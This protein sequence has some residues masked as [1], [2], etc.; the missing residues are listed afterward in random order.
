M[1]MV[2]ELL[3]SSRNMDIVS[4]L[5]KLLKIDPE[6]TQK[7]VDTRY[8]VSKAYTEADEFIYMQEGPSDIPAAGLIGVLNGLVLNTDKFRIAAIYDDCDRLIEFSFL[9]MQ[10]GKFVGVK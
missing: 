7:L 4:Q 5:N 3:E 9:E 6:L 2:N 1:N 10:D 8:P